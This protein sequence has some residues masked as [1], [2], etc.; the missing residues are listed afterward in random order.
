M[1][2]GL[3]ENRG[4]I[5]DRNIRICFRYIKITTEM[6]IRV[7]NKNVLLLQWYDLRAM[8]RLT[9]TVQVWLGT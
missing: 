2:V 6:L 4:T 5:E 1:E 7:D 8:L 9:K 3:R